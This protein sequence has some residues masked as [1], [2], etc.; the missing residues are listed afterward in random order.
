MFTQ[1][2]EISLGKGQL[3]LIKQFISR[4]DCHKIFQNLQKSTKWLQATVT[5]YNKKHLTPRLI[6]WMA[7]KGINYSY[8]GL[9]HEGK[10]WNKQVSQLKHSIDKTLNTKFNGVLMNYYRDGQDSMGWHKDNE[11]ELGLNPKIAILSLG[12]NRILKFKNNQNIKKDIL[13]ENGDLLFFD[14]IVQHDFLSF[15][16][17]N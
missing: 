4:D 12:G 14:G 1:K 6:Y 3:T 17:K 16:I 8:S 11:P 10:G 2:I 9:T 5:I 13:L 7:E 15:N